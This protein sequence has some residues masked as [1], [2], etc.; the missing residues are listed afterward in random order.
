MVGLKVFRRWA[1]GVQCAGF[2]GDEGFSALGMGCAVCWVAGD[3][4]FLAC[5]AWGVIW[6]LMR[7]EISEWGFVE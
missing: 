1:W 5:G 4:G 6:F 2:V 3:K 7:L